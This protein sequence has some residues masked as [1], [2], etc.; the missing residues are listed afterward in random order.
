MPL[1]N[2]FTKPDY[3]R[4]LKQY[5][6]TSAIF[7]GTTNILQAFYVKSIEIDTDGAVIG[8]ALLYDDA[9]NKF[10]PGFPGSFSGSVISNGFLLSYVSGLTYN[11]GAGS[12]NVNGTIYPYSG[13]NFDIISGQSGGSRFDLVYITA[14]SPTVL[15]R[16]GVT[17]TN[18]TLPNLQVNELEVGYI[19]V[20]ANFTGGTG[21]TTIQ[22][23]A[24]TVFIYYN[25]GSG[26]GIQR[27]AGGA[28]SAGAGDFSFA[29]GV[30]SIAY[31]YNSNAFG[32]DT[33]AS[34]YA[35]TVV[36][37]YNVATDT[38]LFIVGA[39]TDDLSRLNAFNITNLG[40]TY[41]NKR[42][43]VTN[44]EIET[45]GTTGIGQVLKFDGTKFKP[46]L[47]S[48]TGLTLF[49]G[50]TNFISSITS[51]SL[52]VKALT[53][54]T[55]ITITETDGLITLSLNFS[56]TNAIT[57]IV[58]LTGGT[59]II[60]GKTGTTYFLYPIEGSGGT[61]VTLVDGKLL[62]YSDS[63]GSTTGQNIGTGSEVFAGKSVNELQFRRLSSATP[64]NLT[65]QQVGDTIVFSASSSAVTNVALY[66]DISYSQLIDKITGS[67]LQIGKQYRIVS[68]R[69]NEGAGT[70]GYVI[71]NAID[72]DKISK[73][74]TLIALNPD[75]YN[76][77]NY[78]DVA[79]TPLG[80]S[81]IAYSG[82]SLVTNQTSIYNNNHYKVTANT[83]FN[84]TLTNLSLLS[85]DFVN[86]YG[87][88]LAN[89][90]IEYDFTSDTITKRV[91]SIGNT[92][93]GKSSIDVFP[94]GRKNQV[95][96]NRVINNSVAEIMNFRGIISGNTFDNNA[97]LVSSFDD[98]NFILDNTNIRN[99]VLI[100]AVT[101][102]NTQFRNC[103]ISTDFGL[104]NRTLSNYSFVSKL[105]T[106]DVN[107][108]ETNLNVPS[109]TLD[110]TNFNHFGVFNISAA[111]ASFSIN[112]IQNYNQTYK[113]TFK[114]LVGYL[115]NFIHSSTI[116][117]ELEDT[118]PIDGNYD[119]IITY[120]KRSKA[121]TIFYQENINTFKAL[122]ALTTSTITDITSVDTTGAKSLIEDVSSA[123]TT[124]RTVT[125][126]ALLEGT[127]ITIDDTS[128]PGYLIINSQASGV[129]TVT[130]IQP[131]GSGSIQILSSVTNNDLV[132]KT[133]SAGTGMDITDDGNG[134]ITFKSTA[135]GSTSGGSISGTYVSG[136]TSAGTGN[137]LLLSSITDNN[138]VYKTISAG[139]NISITESN[140]TIIISGS[141]GISGNF[142]PISGGTLTG[143]LSA[144]TISA[145]SID[146]LDYIDFNTGVT[147]TPTLGRVYFDGTEQA[148][149][150][151]GQTDTPVRIGQQLYSRVI[152]NSGALIPKGTAV[153]IT[154]STSTLPAIT[155]AIA[156]HL[157]DNRVAGI[158]VLDIDN[159]A[160]GLII[161]KGLFSG[162][163]LNNYNVGDSLFLSPFSAGTY[164]SS[165]TSFPFN[166]RVNRLGRVVTTG[167]TTGQ[168]FVDISN[169][170]NTLSLTSIE[171]NI[172]EG[173]V[174]STG[175][176]EYTGLTLGTGKTINIAPLRGWIVQNTYEYATQPEVTNLYYT[177]GTNVT[178]TNLASAESTFLLINSASTLVQ[179]TTFPTPQERR[180]NIFIGKV[181]HPDKVNIT[182][183]NQTVD[184]DV[185]PISVIRD[186]W[187]PIKLI[188]Q[189]VVVSYYS[190]GTMNIQTSS[191]SLWGNG[192]GWTTNQLNPNSVSI[193]GTSPTTFQYRS[194]NGAITGSTGLPAAPTGNTTTID[195]HHYDLNGS[196]V[197]LGG[198]NRASN[199][200]VYLFPTGLIRIQYGQA[201]YSSIANA[202]AGIDTEVFDEYSNNRD[203]GIL[204]GILTVRQN[205]SDLSDTG[206]AQF[207][208]VSKFG[209]LLGGA[210]GISTTTLQQAYNNSATPEI[211]TNSAENA[212]T[213]K[214]GA[215]ADN[216]SNLLEGQNSGGT[217]TSFIRADG[218][219]SASTFLGT[220]LNLTNTVNELVI[221]PSFV[222][223]TTTNLS[224]P[225]T[226]TGTG[227]IVTVPSI[228]GNENKFVK[229]KTDGLGFDYYDNYQYMDLSTAQAGGPFIIGQWYRIP[230]SSRTVTEAS[231]YNTYGDVILMAVDTNKFSPDGYLL[232]INADYQDDGDY[233]DIPD[234]AT[235]HGV[236]YSGLV[237][238]T[239]MAATV[240]IVIYNNI[241]WSTNYS[242][243]TLTDESSITSNLTPLTKDYTTK[244]GYIIEPQKIVYNLATDT[245]NRMEDKRG[246]I[247][248][249]EN[250]DV[251]RF[252]DNNV[253]FNYVSTDNCHLLNYPN[254]SFIRN[255]MILGTIVTP[256]DLVPSSVTLYITRCN[257]QD[258]YFQNDYLQTLYITT[259]NIQ[260]KKTLSGERQFSLTSSTITIPML[261]SGV[262]WYY[263]Q[264]INLT[265]G[266]FNGIVTAI[267]QDNQISGYYQKFKFT[268]TSGS[269][270]IFRN[271]TFI[272]TEGGL[273]A[274]L[275]YFDN[276]E[277]HFFGN[278][279][280]QTDINNYV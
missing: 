62:V 155:P 242:Q 88:I 203:N 70:F 17:T 64:T 7:S 204:I 258:Y 227:N 224:I 10:R 30:N 75:Y 73:N 33:K 174:V 181:V 12:Y 167:T 277:F 245:I 200:R 273:D 145:T 144:T 275:G 263:D 205:A 37:K 207:R 229:V 211:V 16:T 53:A 95:L 274:T 104:V 93:E 29:T 279:A 119:E 59:S 192:I 185:S 39:G 221:T 183:L 9:N 264:V 156:S 189:G 90:Y 246:N 217:I 126:K 202:I 247:V 280:Y 164:T 77:G 106:P 138:L 249:S 165:T 68:G 190:S 241:H 27:A 137:I 188:N 226:A 254:L 42:L 13:E 43:F 24:D 265:G 214:N 48:V 127:N 26:T 196:I 175:T 193:S 71:V 195:G 108:L 223:S 18:P 130:G 218:T 84:N 83:T 21:S 63:S 171:R 154:G 134:T 173:N 186:L 66:E 150:Y 122:S 101:F 206:D 20:P 179:Q 136:L 225:D 262:G 111:T 140:D 166:S 82:Q 222:N 269:N 47:E 41:A 131:V 65:I 151:Y 220:G 161:T 113:L 112:A 143:G 253:N 96:S 234:L 160:T 172:L 272:K 76:V 117:N 45:T 58:S 74:G 109:N 219:I 267:T 69:I 238:G 31:G 139:T 129:T 3:S 72:I 237:V 142:L 23:T 239:V 61:S 102:T 278:T 57:D 256:T 54:S 231:N 182:S 271:S 169:E 158:T 121:G 97:R 115:F 250:I 22:T 34:G 168:I 152:N 40:D 147:I 184:F 133:I 99:N 120:Q 146:R 240:D 110:L 51:N 276:I 255:N 50:G 260:D 257:I 118:H 177:G 103:D 216:V 124:G 86:D 128:A 44:F 210:G 6:G 178:I 157:G 266:T 91:D 259:S 67:T 197:S 14:G 5:S 98:T 159:G 107:Q 233:S 87:Y 114:P 28:N 2:Y 187:T 92:V 116:K 236:P 89:D 191:G 243:Y 268:N 199:Q 46:Q 230:V 36:G 123:S 1:D 270:I 149:T 8:S 248:D 209:E 212:L 105:V 215:G 94:W 25:N 213:I 244:N 19:F 170:D 194:R 162:L 153:K 132:Y 35:Q 251:F 232:A 11:V 261:S 32:Y 81:G 79:V 198:S 252:G 56:G 125:F 49:T 235:K 176:Y 100:S 15:V 80:S 163:T 85:R 4:Q 38:D 141:G 148:L 60:S 201:W 55:G 78:T 228:G 52:L 208:F 180:Q 135:T